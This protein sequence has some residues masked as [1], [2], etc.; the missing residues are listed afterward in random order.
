MLSSIGPFQI[1]EEIGRGGMGTVYRGIDPM[2]GRPVAI[3][4]IRL[5]GYND[6]EEQA[7]LRSR[8]FREARAAGRLCH[9]GIVTIYQVGEERDLAYIAMEF[10]DGLS[11]AALLEAN[12]AP[13]PAHLRRI[14]LEVAEALDYAH[15][16]GLV[17]RDIKPENIMLTTAGVAK[18]TDF[19]IAKTM[20]GQTGASTRMATRDGAMAGTPL[21]MSPEQIRGRELDGRSDQF[22]LAVIAYRIFTGRVPFAAEHITGV[23]Y[24]II[25]EEPPA[26]E[27]ICP[28]I[29]PH[30]SAVLQRGLAKD[31]R[32][33]FPT[34]TEFVRA[35]EA[36]PVKPAP[37]KPIN[38]W[39]EAAISLTVTAGLLLAG[40]VITRPAPKAVPTPASAPEPIEHTLLW[41]GNA[42]PGDLITISGDRASIGTISG[43][44]PAKP[45]HIQI[46]PAAITP[47]DADPRHATD[48]SI[49]ETPVESTRLVVRANAPLRAFL[50]RW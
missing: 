34:C 50:I 48:L 22:A 30:I 24:Q 28:G 15:A 47:E 38:R 7:W 31:P 18:V 20:L 43:A 39:K 37:R 42:Q 13:D 36:T 40:T 23:C 41:T 16:R 27:E 6:A 14:L 12:P 25:H 26:A 5:L 29:G 45:G 10:V 9:P 49:Y 4:I 46:D 2:I 44:L 17:H 11:L 33:R 35:L 3:K 1:L 8:L 19:G 32:D 21:Y